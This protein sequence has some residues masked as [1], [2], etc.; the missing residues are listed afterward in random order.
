[1]KNVIRKSVLLAMGKIS[2]EV[3]K[4]K[5]KFVI[6][7]LLGLKEI[8]EAKRIMVYVSVKKEVYTHD[9][10]KTMGSYHKEIVVPKIDRLRGIMVPCLIK[11]VGELSVGTFKIL[12]PFDPEEI[13]KSTIGLFIIPG[14]AFDRKGNRIGR[15]YGYWDRFLNNVDK[16]LV[17]GL[18]FESQIVKSINVES[19][20]IRVSKIVT[21]DRVIRCLN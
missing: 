20:D 8:G 16:R 9:L 2:E 6:E 3:V 7:N 5:S 19:H 15:G 17:I 11:D 4:Y 18:S 12:E 21:E 10:I 1:M 13:D 14:L